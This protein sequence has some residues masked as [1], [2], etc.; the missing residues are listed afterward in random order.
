M[1]DTRVVCCF[2]LGPLRPV[3]RT[4]VGRL[5]A[6]AD[7]AGGPSLTRRLGERGV[8]RRGLWRRRGE[9]S[10]TPAEAATAVGPASVE[11]RLASQRRGD[12]SLEI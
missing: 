7:D 6:V 2:V 3:L 9:A 5:A 4:L 10:R 1:T 8:A 11:A 12:R